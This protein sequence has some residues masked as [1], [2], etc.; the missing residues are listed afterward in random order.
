MEE[1]QVEVLKLET[2]PL[3]SAATTL[4]GSGGGGSAIGGSRAWNHPI[5]ITLSVVGVLFEFTSGGAA[6]RPETSVGA[7]K[8]GTSAVAGKVGLPLKIVL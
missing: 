4:F 5:G 2:K 8:A 3:V 6:C 7:G 1:V